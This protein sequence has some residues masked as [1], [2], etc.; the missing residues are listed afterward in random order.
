MDRRK[1]ADKDM[2]GCFYTCRIFNP[3]KGDSAVTTEAALALYDA[4]I[5]EVEK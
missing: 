5:A 2:N 4:R 1:L 3:K